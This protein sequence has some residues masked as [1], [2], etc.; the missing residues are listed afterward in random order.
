MWVSHLSRRD[1]LNS[2]WSVCSRWAVNN[3]VKL[4][5]SYC[6]LAR[7]P[8]MYLFYNIPILC[9]CTTLCAF[10]YWPQ[11]RLQEVQYAAAKLLTA[12]LRKRLMWLQSW[13][14]YTGDKQITCNLPKIRSLCAQLRCVLLPLYI[15]T[16]RCSW[17][18]KNVW[19]LWAEWGE[20]WNPVYT[21][22]HFMLYDNYCLKWSNSS[23]RFDRYR[24]LS[25]NWK[26]FDS[27]C[28]SS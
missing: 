20:K 11:R 25:V 7:H 13:F 23:F 3:I 1:L 22:H 19:I 16:E 2:M 26:P 17:G 24:G 15:E 18:W 14:L 10:A 27:V 28:A 9:Y 6:V 8:W 21:V 4:T 5:A 12:D